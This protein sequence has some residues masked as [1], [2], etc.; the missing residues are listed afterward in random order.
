MDNI[1]EMLVDRMSGRSGEENLESDLSTKE[2]VDRFLGAQMEIDAASIARQAGANQHDLQDIEE[3]ISILDHSAKHWAAQISDEELDQANA[4]GS[5]SS[6]EFL[7]VKDR[8][9]DDL[10]QRAFDLTK[11]Y[12]LGS[13]DAS[14]QNAKQSNKSGSSQS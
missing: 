13:D 3:A 5:I 4:N 7:A 6:A 9:A 1:P 12:D 2:K 8:K 14:V 10:K 11:E